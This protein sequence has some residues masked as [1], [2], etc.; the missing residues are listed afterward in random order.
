[1]IARKDYDTAVGIVR[2]E[3]FILI[4]MRTRSRSI[5]VVACQ[6]GRMIGIQNAMV[7]LFKSK[8]RKFDEK[9]FREDCN[10]QDYKPTAT[11]PSKNVRLVETVANDSVALPQSKSIAS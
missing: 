10:A 4:K 3:M 1:M 9:K 11:K 7:A 6:Y 5:V 8:D 2:A